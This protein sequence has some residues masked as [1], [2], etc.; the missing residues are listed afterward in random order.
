[1]QAVSPRCSGRAQAYSRLTSGRCRKGAVVEFEIKTVAD[2]KEYI[3]H[4]RCRFYLLDY[5]K[6]IVFL[7]FQVLL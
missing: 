3:R 7:D 2:I 6:V 1:M 4:C 5:Q